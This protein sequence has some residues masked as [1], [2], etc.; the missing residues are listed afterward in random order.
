MEDSVINASKFL[1]FKDKARKL[2][3]EDAQRDAHIIKERNRDR[4]AMLEKTVQDNSG[5]GNLMPSYSS[6]NAATTFQ[7]NEGEET[8]Q[9]GQSFDSRMESLR[10][11]VRMS[12]N[13]ETPYVNNT[14]KSGLPKEILESFQTTQID[15]EKLNPNQSILDLMGVVPSEPQ[16]KVYVKETVEHTPTKSSGTIDYSLIKDII[17]STV[18]KY[19]S[20]YSKRIIEE[21]KKNSQVSNEVKAIKIGDKFS[22]ITENGDIYEAQL[23]FKKNINKK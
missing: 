1:K 18:K 4:A 13:I 5:Y 23:T 6:S 8:D 2:I 14:R 20:G 11:K 7:V 22:F 9:I 19:M 21:N 16:E 12:E 10:N 17:E 3:H 15:Y